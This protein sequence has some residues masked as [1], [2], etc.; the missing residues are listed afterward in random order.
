MEGFPVSIAVDVRFSEMDAQG[1]V[2][3]A[4][5]LVWFEN[6][7]IEYIA[8]LPGGYAGMVEQGVDVTTIEARVR[9]RAAT[10]F[11]DNLRVHVRVG[12]VKGPRFRFEYAVERKGK[13]VAEG[14][15]VHACVDASTLRPIRIPPDLL[16]TIERLEG[17]RG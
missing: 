3:H 15:T 16:E 10:R 12:E 9:Y 8:R 6:A 11:G 4:V 13:L 7:R 17:A 2:H 5:Y 14:W 1:I